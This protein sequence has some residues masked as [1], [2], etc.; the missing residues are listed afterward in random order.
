[1]R[2][3][4]RSLYFIGEIRFSNGSR[5][6]AP[7]LEFP[8][9]TRPSSK[10]S[11][12]AFLALRDRDDCRLIFSRLI[13]HRVGDRSYRALPIPTFIVHGRAKQ[14]VADTVAYAQKMIAEA[15]PHTTAPLRPRAYDKETA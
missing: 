7:R 6:C 11:K 9:S 13:G 15:I 3:S 4:G 8:G 2:D 14:R 5:S 10:L 12:T 1:V